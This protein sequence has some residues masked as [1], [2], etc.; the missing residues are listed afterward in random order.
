MRPFLR[1]E[2]IRRTGLGWLC[3][4]DLRPAGNPLAE[5]FDFL[6][7]QLLP[8]A[9]GH[10]AVADHGEK[11][12]FLRFAGN[13]GRPLLAAFGNEMPQP[14][15]EAALGFAFLAV[16]VE[17]VRLQDGPDVLLERQRA[18]RSGLRGG[19]CHE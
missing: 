14:H 6:R 19:R 16:A 12:A 3:P 11:Q 4:R 5:Q 17:A 7:R 9:L 1:S 18:S 2:L 15:V 10:L 13:D 8:L